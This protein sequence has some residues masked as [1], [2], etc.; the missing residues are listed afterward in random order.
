M[1]LSLSL[2]RVAGAK[3][4]SFNYTR[5]MATWLLHGPQRLFHATTDNI[6]TGHAQQRYF[7]LH[8]LY[9]TMFSPLS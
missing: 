9:R 4:F 7:T 3:Q 2:N 1:N 8:L 5:L 6:A